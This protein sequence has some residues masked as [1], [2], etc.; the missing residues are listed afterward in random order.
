[1][2]IVLSFGKEPKTTRHLQATGEKLLGLLQIGFLQI[3]TG[4][5]YSKPKS[6]QIV[7]KLTSNLFIDLGFI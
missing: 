7:L 6:Q 3:T 2:R 4:N 1:M 5:F